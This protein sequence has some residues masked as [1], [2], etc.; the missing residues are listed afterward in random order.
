MSIFPTR[1]EQVRDNSDR[2]AAQYLELIGQPQNSPA[3]ILAAVV[4]RATK[5]NESQLLGDALAAFQKGLENGQKA[6]DILNSLDPRIA[7]SKEFQDRAG[8]IRDDRIKQTAEDRAQAQWAN[9]LRRQAMQDRADDLYARYLEN[10]QRTN[11]L[12]AGSFYEAYKAE[13]AANPIARQKII[14]NAIQTGADISFDPNASRFTTSINPDTIG[15]DIKEARNNA[16]LSM[17]E[18]AA[19]GLNL[20]DNPDLMAATKGLQSFIDTGAKARGYTGDDYSDYAENV[21]REFHKISSALRDR[22]ISIPENIILAQMYRNPYDAWFGQDS[23]NT[24]A[25]IE[26]LSQYG[27]T[28]L[29]QRQK[30]LEAKDFLDAYNTAEEQK[31]LSNAAAT[32]STN[33]RRLDQLRN[34]GYLTEAQ[35][36]DQLAK[37]TRLYD[38]ALATIATKTRNLLGRDLT[39]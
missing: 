23:V 34:S 19:L 27:S 12:G 8:D 24:D 3:S 13:L 22:K 33:L 14:Q 15:T 38:S 7:G 35:Y 28:Y 39:Q 10:Q 1:L 2:A 16:L 18:T 9:T 21:T 29:N 5:A 30:Y 37:A 36:R 11:G 32:L 4:D 26:N 6:G 31:V 25:I 17:D 20:E